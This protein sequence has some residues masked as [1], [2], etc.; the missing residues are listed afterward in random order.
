MESIACE[1][2]AL[3]VLDLLKGNY[4]LFDFVPWGYPGD[5]DTEI[6]GVPKARESFLYD[7]ERPGDI[8]GYWQWL[9]DAQRAGY[10]WLQTDILAVRK[11]IL[12][13][14]MQNGIRKIGDVCGH[15]EDDDVDCL[16]REMD[17]DEN[18]GESKDEL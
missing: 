18:V 2:S 15:K 6:T 10:R 7:T 1:A 5:R 12:C 11:D 4:V 13:D 16:L 17:V 14:T 9:C 8:D 3:R